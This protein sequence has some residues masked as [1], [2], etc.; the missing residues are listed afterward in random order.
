[1]ND[2]LK[3]I[4]IPV[5]IVVAVI[6]F[7]VLAVILYVM[8]EKISYGTKYYD[9][10][11][12]QYFIFYNDGTCKGSSNVLD[13]SYTLEDDTIAVT[14]HIDTTK[15][16]GYNAE[17]GYEFKILSK[18]QIERVKMTVLG[19]DMSDGLGDIWEVGIKDF[20]TTTTEATKPYYQTYTILTLNSGKKATITFGKNGSCDVDFSQFNNSDLGPGHSGTSRS[21]TTVTY[22]DGACNYEVVDDK[23][24]IIDYKGIVSIDYN[25]YMDYYKKM[26]KTAM[27]SSYVLKNAAITFD[28]NYASFKFT[29]GE[30]VGQTGEIFYYYYKLYEDTENETTTTVP[31]ENETNENT[32]TKKGQT[33]TVNTPNEKTTTKNSNNK[34]TTSISTTK[35]TTKK[36]TVTTTAKVKDVDTISIDL[37]DSRG[38]SYCVRLDSNGDYY[39]RNGSYTVTI[40]GESYRINP[41]FPVACYYYTKKGNH[42]LDVTVAD[43]DGNKKTFNN[44]CINFTPEKLNYTASVSSGYG[45]YYISFGNKSEAS[46]N[47]SNHY[48][49]SNNITVYLDGEK[50]SS[51]F[52][53]GVAFKDCNHTI[54]VTNKFGDS[55][56]I[57]LTC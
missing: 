19:Y 8:S 16:L 29:N 6:L 41:G 4:L 12:T 31:K 27:G 3:K 24:L 52:Y 18:N 35:T 51:T 22:T 57:N 30:F 55:Q 23:N 54:K 50:V 46:R 43:S 1:M 13:C 21:Y 40:E 42:C 26:Q 37:Y 20:K 47:D 48:N 28:D 10:Y 33:T 49:N 45:G 39:A 14:T 38:T 56:T 7:V 44:Q 25:W 11:G 36:T 53:V 34:T 5:G 9:E 15:L 2:K 17:Y 32:T